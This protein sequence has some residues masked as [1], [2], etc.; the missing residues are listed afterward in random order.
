M[1]QL[2]LIIFF[3]ISC[4]AGFAQKILT[5]TDSARIQLDSYTLLPDQ[6]YSFE[7]VLTDT[8]LHFVRNDSIRPQQ[9]SAYWLKIKLANPSHYTQPYMLRVRPVLQNTL[10]YFN[11][12]S[13]TWVST[14]AGIMVAADKSLKQGNLPFVLQGGGVINI[15]YVKLDLKVLQTVGHALRPEITITS[16]AAADS[17]ERVLWISWVVSIT[18]LL[19]FF[20]HNLYIYYSFRDKA[21]LYYLVAQLGAMVY[22]TAYKHFFDLVFESRVFTFDLKA[23]G[24][25][26]SYNYGSIF[27]HG[28]VLVMMYGFVQ[29]TRSYLNTRQLL[30]RFDVALKY[31]LG[32]YMVASVLLIVINV[33]LFFVNDY[34]LLYENIVV[35]ALAATMLCAGV[36]AYRRKQPAAGTFLVANVLPLGCIVAVSVY[37]VF[38]KLYEVETSLLPDMA[39]VSQALVFSVALVARMRLIQKELKNSEIEARQLAF[40]IREIQLKHQLIELENAQITA[41]ILHHKN[42]N[43]ALQQKLETNQ[44]ELAAN[45]LYMVQ[46][47]KLLTD[48]Q[49]QIK[50]INK[51]YPGDTIGGGLKEMQSA[52]K[53]N[54]SLDE[55]WGKFKLHFEQ[56]HPRFFDDLQTK[57]PSFTKNDIRLY[58]YFHMN[59]S[60]KEVAALMNIDP[61][62]VRQAKAR[63]NK[64]MAI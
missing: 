55:D 64:K 29:L 28:S 3:S 45:A 6:G 24:W 23:D 38:V 10:Y 49:N 8:T 20:L 39:V 43:K 7:Q 57:H 1:G 61:A 54:L 22:I 40:D 50:Q 52:L 36:V 19:L 37:H 42:D 44:R 18:V 26:Y 21:I 17:R 16:L 58:A 11:A 12:D 15:L 30:P 33:S 41:D 53:S 31:G 14:K 47:N 51:Q 13:Q 2:L 62:S 25:L 63:L 5:L 59:L 35:L 56:V 60:T 46:K 34:S 4:I 9:A 32:S 27:M 48:L